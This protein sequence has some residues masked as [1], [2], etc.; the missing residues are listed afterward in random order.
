MQTKAKTYGF[1][2]A[3]S[4]MNSALK[5]KQEFEKEL[6]N[7]TNK[8]ISQ[9][10]KQKISLPKIDDLNKL[11]KIL[12]KEINKR[13][14]KAEKILENARL[15]G[16]PMS[17][18]S[19]RDLEKLESMYEREYEGAKDKIIEEAK[20]QNFTIRRYEDLTKMKEE[21]EKKIKQIKTE[22]NAILDSAKRHKLPMAT[23]SERNLEKLQSRYNEEYAEAKAAIFP[24]V[25]NLGINVSP[26]TELATLQEIIAR[27][28]LRE[29]YIKAG[30]PR[31]I[32][33]AFVE[34]KISKNAVLR[35]AR[36]LGKKHDA[37]ELEPHILMVLGLNNAGIQWNIGH[38]MFHN[39]M[40][41]HR[42]NG[43]LI[44]YMVEKLE[45]DRE[46]FDYALM[47]GGNDFSNDDF[48]FLLRCKKE[49]ALKSLFESIYTHG[50]D[51]ITAKSMIVDWGLDKHPEALERVIDGADL[52]LI[53]AMYGIYQL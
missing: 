17:T 6:T 4:A 49:H 29:G 43:E 30:I 1:S 46:V 44:E 25:K 26:K 14:L 38:F 28:G 8:I 37:K 50:F 11:R 35:I 21:Y 41:K 22:V 42:T 51:F 32:I 7:E 13:N 16:F 19:E 52:E 40:P 48:D 36:Y 34:Q 24:S 47:K 23:T 45:Q 53:A 5:F 3:K 20:K 10:N 12:E 31:T 27:E 39:E 9:A 33:D 18:T 2:I 15:H